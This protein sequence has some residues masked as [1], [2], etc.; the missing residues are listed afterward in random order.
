MNWRHRI[1]SYDDIRYAWSH[2][3]TITGLCEDT[4][5]CEATHHGTTSRRTE[6]DHADVHKIQINKQRSPNNPRTNKMSQ[7]SKRK[8]AQAKIPTKS[9]HC[10]RCGY[11]R[12]HNNGKC[13]AEGQKCNNCSKYKH[14]A[15]VC[16]SK[17]KIREQF[18]QDSHAIWNDIR[19]PHSNNNSNCSSDESSDSDENAF[20]INEVQNQ[21]NTRK[22]QHLFNANLKIG[23]STIPFQID[24][25]SSVNIIDETTFQ[26]IKKNNPKIVLRK[27][28][29]RLFG[30]GSQTPLPLVGQFECVLE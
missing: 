27:S 8:P 9:Q 25:G 23:K 2:I 30:F 26:R 24:S 10:F 4:G 16:N 12:P 15:S 5:L 20:T 11:S 7:H 21:P 1:K 18:N 17:D 19:S 14:F 28:R 13:P 29:K 22:K 6:T 3:D